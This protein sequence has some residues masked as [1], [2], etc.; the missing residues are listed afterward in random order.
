M[1]L[2]FFS[3]NLVAKDDSFIISK[4][5]V[6]KVKI[7]GSINSFYGVFEKHGPL[8]LSDKYLEATFTP[9]IKVYDLKKNLALEANIIAENGNFLLGSIEIFSPLFYTTKE[10]RVGSVY[11]QLLKKY[12]QVSL[13]HFHGKIYAVVKEER[14]SFTLDFPTEKWPRDMSFIKDKN[15]KSVIPSK[16]KIKSIIIIK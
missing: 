12:K 6:G 9:V 14:L 11:E 5:R 15:L 10:V 2:I 13:D 7:G 16:T 3:L 4:G 1:F 8:T